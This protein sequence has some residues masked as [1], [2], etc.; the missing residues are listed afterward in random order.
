VSGAGR[1]HTPTIAARAE[2][3]QDRPGSAGSSDVVGQV[4]LQGAGQGVQHALQ[5]PTQVAPLEL[6][7][8]LDTDP[9]QVGNL[10]ATQ[11]RHAPVAAGQD[12][13]PLRWAAGADA[14]ATVEQNVGCHGHRGS[15]DDH[16]QGAGENDTAHV[17]ADLPQRGAH[18]SPAAPAGTPG[19]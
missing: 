9:G 8:V 14:V 7:V 17:R 15:G 19:A 13:P 11:P 16:E 6:G 5:D 3:D 2:G 4:Q 10:A 18:P 1:T 12:E